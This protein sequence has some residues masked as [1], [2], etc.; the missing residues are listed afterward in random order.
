MINDPV[1]RIENVERDIKPPTQQGTGNLIESY[2]Q[3]SLFHDQH[4]LYVTAIT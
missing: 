2:K 3:Q 4:I 1:D